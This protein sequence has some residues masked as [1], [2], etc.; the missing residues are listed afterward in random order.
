MEIPFGAA[1]SFQ[2][3]LR[4]DAETLVGG[5]CR[6]HCN[7]LEALPNI[8]LCTYMILECIERMLARKRQF[9]AGARYAASAAVVAAAAAA[10][11]EALA[12]LHHL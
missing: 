12:I 2:H 6:L 8:Q 9:G 4:V 3:R 7:R 1:V 5:Y 10:A 11:A